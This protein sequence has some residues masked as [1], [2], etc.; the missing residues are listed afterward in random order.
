[1]KLRNRLLLVLAT[2]S[3]TLATASPANAACLTDTVGGASSVSATAVNPTPPSTARAIQWQL[4][5]NNIGSS[6]KCQALL[7]KMKAAY[8]SSYR[9]MCQSYQAAACPPQTRWALW[10]GENNV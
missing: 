10:F 9:W 7:T 3:L 5:E 4:F 6:G 2:I 1:M 8:P